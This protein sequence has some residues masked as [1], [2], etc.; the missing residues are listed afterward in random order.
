MSSKDLITR[1]IFSKTFRVNIYVYYG[2]S[3]KKFAEELDRCG[4]D[5]CGSRGD[6]K[7]IQTNYGDIWLWTK[8][9]SIPVLVHEAFHAA[10][11]ILD[12]KGVKLSDDSDEIYAYFISMIVRET[13]TPSYSV[14]LNKRKKK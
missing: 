9:K 13:L 4:I 6:G 12:G 2:L 1:H 3:V 5:L 7:T 8:H 10:H 14:K 11:F